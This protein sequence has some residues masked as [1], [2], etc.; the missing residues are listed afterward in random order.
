MVAIV[1]LTFLGTRGEIKA[2]TPQHRMHS[3]LLVRGNNCVVLIDC[4]ADWLNRAFEVRPHA[5]FLTHAHSDHAA[6]LRN[7]A[8]CEV[9][10][11]VDTWNGVRGFAI[12]RR[13]LIRLRDAV[14][15]RDL[16]FEAFPVEHSLIAPAVGFRISCRR[17]SIFYVPDVVSIIHQEQALSGISTYIGDGASISR[18]LVRTRNGAQ[19]GHASI[20]AQLQWCQQEG[21]GRAIFTHCGSQIVTANEKQIARRI[22]DLGRK[23]A[24]EASIANDG[25]EI[26]V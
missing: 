12:Q 6:G 13:S 8:P 11:T 18:P 15:I 22:E 9:F 3:S 25:L 17:K 5:I 4:G 26:T 1:K 7:G 10:A 19:I 14:R 20:A 24:L 23:L 21:V 16:A 2:R